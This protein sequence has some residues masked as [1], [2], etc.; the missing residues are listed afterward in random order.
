MKKV[1]GFKNTV[2][3]GSYILAGQHKMQYTDEVG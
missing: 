2:T 3:Q 1:K